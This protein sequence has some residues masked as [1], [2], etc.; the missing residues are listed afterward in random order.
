MSA[1]SNDGS[2][3]SGGAFNDGGTEGPLPGDQDGFDG[4][5][6]G[7]FI[8]EAHVQQL[9]AQVAELNG[10]YLRT[11][12]DYQNSQRRAIQN[13]QEARLQ[14]RSGVIQSVLSVVDHFD[15]ALMQD[16]SKTTVEQIINGVKVIRDELLKVLQSQGVKLIAPAAGAEFEPSLHQAIM[17]Q[18]AEGVES[19]KI[20]ATL[21][22]GYVISGPSGDRV[23]RAAKVSV[24]P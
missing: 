6:A 3:R 15:L 4:T 18:S 1:T 14:A 12:A 5:D 24:A 8:D 11:L 2:G 21:Q 10:K 20:V 17:Q 22:A 7:A 19:G 23:V 13:E 16:P 9:E